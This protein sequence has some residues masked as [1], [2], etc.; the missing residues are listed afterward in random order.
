MK[1]KRLYFLHIHKTGGTFFNSAI[2]EPEINNLLKHGINIQPLRAQSLTSHWAWHEDL[3]QDDSYIV[4]IFRDPVERL[5][6]NFCD[7]QKDMKHEIPQGYEKH[8]TKDNFYKFI[9]SIDFSISE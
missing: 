7:W 9:I 6:S 2:I 4:T 5:V 3:V 8:I 1:Y